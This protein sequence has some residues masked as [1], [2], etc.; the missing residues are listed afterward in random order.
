MALLGLGTAAPVDLRAAK[1]HMCICVRQMI[2]SVARIIG[3]MAIFMIAGC[4]AS[5]DQ[6]YIEADK[7]HRV[8]ALIN[9]F[10]VSSPDSWPSSIENLRDDAAQMGEAFESALDFLHPSTHQKAAWLLLDPRQQV[11]RGDEYKILAA[12]PCVGGP[13]VERRGKRLILTDAGRILWLDETSFARRT[14]AT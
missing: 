3:I 8:F 4:Y 9:R 14:R 11:S 7:L 5:R 13:T 2:R 6:W 12:A 1:D 10:R